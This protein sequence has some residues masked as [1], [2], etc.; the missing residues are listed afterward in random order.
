M[1][2]HLRN[3]ILCAVLIAAVLGSNF[4]EHRKVPLITESMVAIIV[5]LATMLVADAISHDSHPLEDFNPNFFFNVLLPPI[6]FSAGC[7]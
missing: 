4:I 2:T 5:G 1:D 3:A 7:P 6:V